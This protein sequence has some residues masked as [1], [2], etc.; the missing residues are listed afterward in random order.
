MRRS[1]RPKLWLSEF[2]IQSDKHFQHLPA[3]S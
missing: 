2:T 3:V 1:G